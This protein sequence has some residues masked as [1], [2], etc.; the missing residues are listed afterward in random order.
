MVTAGRSTGNVHGMAEVMAY[1]IT[2]SASIS[3]VAV[4]A[5]AFMRQG[6]TTAARVRPV[7]VLDRMA[8]ATGGALVEIDDVESL[9]A[10]LVRTVNRLHKA[11]VLGFQPVARDGKAHL[12]SVRVKR[13][14]VRVRA[15][16]GYVAGAGS[17]ERPEQGGV[18][19]Q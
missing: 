2:A 10:S 1:A 13:A 19:H 11:Y 18:R 14:G 15:K 9:A 3:F 7:V 6:G 5:G 17:G 8:A 4:P 16:A 12:L